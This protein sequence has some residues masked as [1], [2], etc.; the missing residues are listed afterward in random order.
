MDKSFHLYNVAKEIEDKFNSLLKSGKMRLSLNLEEASNRRNVQI[1]EEWDEDILQ[2]KRD[3]FYKDKK[4]TCKKCKIIKPR[5]Q[6]C[7]SR[8]NE[9]G[10][11]HHCKDCEIKYKKGLIVR[12]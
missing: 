7:H 6:F 1:D 4:Y 5:H 10:I 9:E 12:G 11:S 2:E 3:E 8:L